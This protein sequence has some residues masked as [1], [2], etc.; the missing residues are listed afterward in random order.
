MTLFAAWRGMH[1]L[2]R[3][4]IRLL[5]EEHYQTI[6]RERERVRELVS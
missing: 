5:V 1:M 3:V 4:Q 2:F 6:L